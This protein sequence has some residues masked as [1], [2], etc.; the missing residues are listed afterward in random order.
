MVTVT[1]APNTS[2]S[3]TLIFILT[4]GYNPVTN[5]LTLNVHVPG[6][7]ILSQPQSTFAELGSDATFTVVANGTLPITYQWQF[8]GTN[9][10]GET[11]PS[12][13]LTNVQPSQSG[14]Y[15][16]IIGNGNETLAS[17]PAVLS[18]A[19]VA[20]LGV[21]AGPIVNPANGRHYFLLEAT[22]WTNAE[23]AAVGMG[24]HLAT[25]DSPEDNSWVYNTFGNFNGS[26]RD[27]WIGLYDPTPSA[28]LDF[29]NLKWT[30]LLWISGY[31]A[32]FE[33]WSSA[34][35]PEWNTNGLSWRVY[36]ICGPANPRTPGSIVNDS[37]SASL[38]AV[39]ELPLPLE[40]VF[41]PQTVSVGIG[42]DASLSVLA[43]GFAPIYYQW[44][45]NGTNLPGETQTTLT[46]TNAKPDQSGLYSL[47]ISNMSGTLTSGPI[48][49]SVAG[50][51]G[52]G[53]S[54]FGGDTRTNISP[55]LTSVRAIVG[56]LMHDLALKADGTVVAWGDNSYNQLSV[57]ADLTNAVALAGAEY[58]SLALRADGTVV[59]W[60]Y[61]LRAWVPEGLSNVV[62]I[63]A[64]GYNNLALKNDGTVVAWG[65]DGASPSIVPSGLSNVV[66]IATASGRDLALKADATV[67]AW[68]DTTAVMIE[69]PSSLT[70][71]VAIAAGEYQ[72][73]ALKGDG[74]VIAFKTWHNQNDTVPGGLTNVAAITAGATHCLALKA[75]GSVVAW[76]DNTGGESTVP[77]NLPNVVATAAG[78]RHSFALLRDGAPS[79]TVQPWDRV[80]PVGASPSLVAKAVGMQSMSYRWRFDGT[81]ITGATSDTYSITN[82]QP[83]NAG[84]YTLVVS[85]GL[86]LLA[87]RQAKFAV[88]SAASAETN[89][90]VIA[91]SNP[92]A[93]T[94]GTPLG[95]VQL[96]AT[97]NVPGTFAYSPAMGTVLNAGRNQTLSVTFSPSDPT[98][99]TSASVTASISVLPATLTVLANT[100]G[101][102]YGSVNPVFSATIS[103][104]VNGDTLAIVSGT[105][106]FCTT[107][108]SSS[109]AGMYNVVPAPG[110]LTVNPNYTIS[111]LNGTL[112][113]NPAT[114]TIASGLTANNKVYDGTTTA[115]LSSNTLAMAG[116]VN[117]DAAN[118]SL[119]TNG[120]TATFAS[121]NVGHSLAVTVGGLTLGGSAAPDYALA[122]PS[123][124]TANI[125]A[126]ETRIIATSL[127]G[128]T[129]QLSV[130]TAPGVN[131][132]LEY[133]NSITAPNWA[134]DQTN[135]GHGSI[136]T[137]TGNVGTN[138]TGFYRIR[139][140]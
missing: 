107:A 133:K 61:N 111:Y 101:R 60:G 85:N 139:I 106:T 123:G 109:P 130:P 91:W 21:L 5:I 97:V 40:I 2:G 1:P 9:L 32:H 71:V 79:M 24:G 39:I 80:V 87:S 112:T 47:V 69:I 120:Y 56:G 116:V 8:M 17:V 84:L 44:Q 20:G 128:Q 83:A 52:W 14:P 76:G 73:L 99:Y 86:G 65:G 46:L 59:A 129:F 53:S 122:Q 11:K 82:A 50:I 34:P 126:P 15:A 64:A 135:A 29:P 43:D 110:T 94:Y 66:G 90:P 12:L 119:V 75:N 132:V 57:P 25:I 127:V 36:K 68:D 78:W 13:T 30:S 81:N 4:G 42:S 104:F 55:G 18:V 10:P 6:L 77:A 51:V 67:V 125:T 16:V 105:P 74:S 118:L 136:V 27:L 124:L 19:G 102:T 114:L 117:A 93:I 37:P 58:H 26:S 28:M 54:I 89:H 98:N 96:D 22:T 134:A 137:F 108:I 131:Y 45:S 31:P 38:N 103:G 49:L 48:F 121:A 23:A 3:G 100:T 70:N 7:S 113:V 41:Q 95:P 115:T 33:D 72:N 62:A 92:T 63:A 35:R 140:Q 88:S 138:A